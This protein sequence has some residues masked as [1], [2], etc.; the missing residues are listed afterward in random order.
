M[1]TPSLTKHE[2]SGVLG[3][4]RV[5]VRA[6]GRDMPRPAVVIVHGFKGFKDWGMFPPLADRL[7]RAGF[8]AVSFNMS[9][10]GV[11]DEGNFTF[12]ERF[13]HDTFSAALEDVESVINTLVAGS[14]EVAPPSSIGLLGHSRGGGIAILET[15]R[16]DR[17]TAL[18]TWAS[19]ST[20]HRWPAAVVAEWRRTGRHDVVNARTGE[21][22]PLYTDVLDDNEAN[23]DHLD[24]LAAA[25]R[26]TAPWLLVHGEADEAVSLEEGQ[27]LAA[28]VRHPASRHEWIAG[29]G[30]T[31]GARHPWAG[32]TPDLERA[33]AA[34]VAWFARYLD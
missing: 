16:D 14:L 19:V 23:A 13:G 29:G 18:V 17:V 28:L 25:S 22:L 33:F 24:I 10:S 6:A 34:S 15:A 3:P 8:V 9:G 26:I 5:D 1:A 7:A 30:H 27:R 21:V 20:V 4:I 31:F 12:P 11:D 32:S 2:I